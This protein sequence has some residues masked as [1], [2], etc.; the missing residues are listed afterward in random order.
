[1]SNTFH[2]MPSS[3]SRTKFDQ[4]Q[5]IKS[6]AAGLMRAEIGMSLVLSPACT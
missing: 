3:M 1:M 2:I 5:Q 4:T 6:T